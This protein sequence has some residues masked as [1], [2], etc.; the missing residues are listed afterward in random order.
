[1]AQVWAGRKLVPP[2]LRGKRAR[3]RVLREQ[4]E[5]LSRNDLKSWQRSSA[6]LQCLDGAS[7]VDTAAS[8]GVTH[9]AVSKWLSGYVE[10]GFEVLRPKRPPGPTSRLSA[11]QLE[12]L[13]RAI[14]AGPEA[15]GFASGIWTALMVAEFIREHFGVTYNWKHV[16]ELLHRI[17]FSVQRPR[18]RLSRADHEAQEYCKSSPCPVLIP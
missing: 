7:L 6:V 14:D 18:K 17:G 16:P 1:M 5:A 11:D 4:R 3:S 2:H 15:A 12:E 10:E 8:L 13:G 9:S